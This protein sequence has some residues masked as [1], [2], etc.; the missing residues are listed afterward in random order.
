[1]YDGS[2][3]GFWG[4]YPNNGWEYMVED[5]GPRKVK[6]KFRGP[7]GGEIEFQAELNGNSISVE[8]GD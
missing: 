8:V 3:I 2:S 7:S 1:V 5:N 6:V 4:A